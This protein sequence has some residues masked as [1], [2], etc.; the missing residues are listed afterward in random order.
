MAQTPALRARRKRDTRKLILKCANALFQ[1]RGFAA[2]TLVDIAAKAGVHKQT[3]LRYFGSKDAIALAFRKTALHRFKTGLHDPAREISVIEYWRSFIEASAREVSKRGD[4]LRYARLIQ[5]EPAL[6]AA[7]VSVHLEYEELLAIAFSREA[8]VSP[9]NDTHSKLL[10]GFLVSGN[11]TLLRHLL[12]CGELDRYPELAVQVVDF[13]AV[14]FGRR[15]VLPDAEDLAE[16][17]R[18]AS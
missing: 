7:S 10:A 16:V 13:V 11:F 3:V 12:S 2:T 15:R 6:L 18:T 5:S 17:M 1:E 8:G 9:Q 14:R 4:L